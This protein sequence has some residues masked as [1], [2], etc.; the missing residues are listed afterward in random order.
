M[1]ASLC[2]EFVP[3][4]TNIQPTARKMSAQSFIM[5]VDVH[6]YKRCKRLHF[7]LIIRY[8]KIRQ[9]QYTHIHIIE[10]EKENKLSGFHNANNVNG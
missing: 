9:W 1:V 3:Y 2:L 8:S 6:T 4:S 5:A 10:L 7:H